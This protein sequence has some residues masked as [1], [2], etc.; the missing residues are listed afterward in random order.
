VVRAYDSQVMDTAK[1]QIPDVEYCADAYAVAEV[2]DAVLA[3]TE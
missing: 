3:L 2:T 1:A